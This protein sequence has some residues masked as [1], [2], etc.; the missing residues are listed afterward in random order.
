VIRKFGYETLRLA[1]DGARTYAVL[2]V[3]ASVVAGLGAAYC[4]MAFAQALASP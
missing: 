3:V 4:G 1:E 2:N